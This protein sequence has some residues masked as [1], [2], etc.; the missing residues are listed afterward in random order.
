M[1]DAIEFFFDFSSPYA[2]FASFGIER[3]A[4]RFGR[5]CLWKPILLGPAFKASGN[6][7]LIDQPLKGAY[8]KH[9][10]ERMGRMMGV[11]YRFPD[12][13]PVATIAAARAFWFLDAQ[14]SALAKDFARKVFAAYFADGQDISDRASVTA[15]AARLGVD[16]V[17]IQ[18]A[19]E[20]PTWKDRCRAETDDAIRRGVFG[21]PFFVLD[22]ESFWGADRLP[23]VESWLERGGW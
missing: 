11:A 22:G 4:E 3:I 17:H 6:Q 2:Y 18:A 15:I 1:T 7:R 19:I 9:D 12:P 21:A 16:P 20:N 13:F 14:D 10:W 8:A 5:P 23:M